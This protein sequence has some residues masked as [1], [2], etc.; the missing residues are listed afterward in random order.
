L[1]GFEV[2]DLT[3]KSLPPEV[4]V[5]GSVLSPAP[6]IELFRQLEAAQAALEVS[7]ESLDRADKL[8]ASGEL[9]ARKEVQTA[10]AQHAQDQRSCEGSMIGSCWSGG[11]GFP[12]WRPPTGRSC[13]VTC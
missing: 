8:F 5:F 10:Q 7:K 9:V 13:G 4:A 12:N 11:C 6:M 2:T 3:A 1:L